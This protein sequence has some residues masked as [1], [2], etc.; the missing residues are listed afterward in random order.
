MTTITIHCPDEVLISLKQDAQ[1][2]QKSLALAA[3][4]KFYELG[5]LTSGRAAELAGVSRVE[6]LH[7]AAEFRVP[8]WDLTE[9][10]LQE[11]L[12]HA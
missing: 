2:F 6:F 11:D 4:M 5:Q 12:R 7:R 1:S 8:A 3:A 10:E 9:A